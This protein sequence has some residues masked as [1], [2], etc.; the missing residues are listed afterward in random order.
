DCGIDKS[1]GPDGFTFGFYHRFWN[2]IENDVYDVV[3][4][5]FTYEV[6]SKGCNSSFIALIPKIPDANTVK[7]FRPISLIGSLYKIVAKIL[8]NR[9]VGVLGDIVNESKIM[10]VLVD[11]DKVKCAA[12]KLGCLILKTPFSYLGSKVGGSMS[13]VH[14]WSDVVDRVKNRLSRWKMKTFSIGGAETSSHLIFSCCMA[15]QTVRMITRWWD[16]P[17]GEVDSYED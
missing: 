13:R 7:D 15:R 3:K 17:Y 10:G 1:P 14:T 11:S 16:V 9:L 6:I 12:S 2:L 4:Y 8:A 5:F